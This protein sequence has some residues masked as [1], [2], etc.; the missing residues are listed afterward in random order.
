MLL[1]DTSVWI[2]MERENISLLPFAAHDDL[3]VCPPVVYE[4]LRGANTRMR[5]EVARR[6]LFGAVMLDDP[7]GAD[8]FEE[9]AQLYL[10]CRQAGFTIEGFDCLIASTAI[11]NGAELLHADDDFDLIARVDTRLGVRRI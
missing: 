10:Q 9:A 4:V 11:A 3:A 7:M 2:A 8:R 5:Y 6:A 1:V